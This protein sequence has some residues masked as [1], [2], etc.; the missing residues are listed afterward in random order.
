MQFRPHAVPSQPASLMPTATAVRPQIV[1]L[2]WLCHPAF[3]ANTRSTIRH[4]SPCQPVCHTSAHS[5]HAK[6]RGCPATPPTM[7]TP[8]VPYVIAP[9]AIPLVIQAPTVSVRTKCSLSSPPTMQAPSAPC[10]TAPS[11]CYP[12]HTSARS[13]RTIKVPP[14][15]PLTM[16]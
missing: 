5:H 9:T 10:D 15:I 3:H 12:F 6:K 8:S 4:S 7:R 14:T 2:P 13:H 16:P 11:T 1:N